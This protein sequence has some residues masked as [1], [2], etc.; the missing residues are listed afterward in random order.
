MPRGVPKAGFRMTR[1]RKAA[2]L[3][4]K[5]IL[6]GASPAMVVPEEPEIVETEDQ[7]RNKLDERFAA[8]TMMAKSAVAGEVR[9]V[10]VSGPAGVG[11][12]YEIEQLLASMNPYHT[13]VRGYVRPTGLYRTLYEFRNPGSVVVFDDADSI[14]NDD[15]SL[16]LLKAACDTTRTRKLSWLSEI[17]MEDEGGDK[18][19]REFEFEGTIIFITNY[20]FD[21]LIARGNKLAPH[22]AALVSRS[23]YLDMAMKNKRDYLVR[24]KQVL[25]KGMLRGVGMSRND[26]AEIVKFVEDNQDKLRELSLRMV[27]K[28][29]TLKKAHPTKWASLARVVCCHTR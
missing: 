28:V 6:S 1:K 9:A 20:D 10:V 21:L 12:S 29:A 7:I 18:M 5:Q 25:E 3:T 17:R 14:F 26:E 16:N 4:R 8:L 19:P 24:I 23:M 27:I 2:G 22:F 11:K 13:I 15:V